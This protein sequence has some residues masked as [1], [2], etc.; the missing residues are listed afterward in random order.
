MPGSYLD[1]FQFLSGIRFITNNGINGFV[2]DTYTFYPPKRLGMLFQAGIIALL[3]N[4]G[5]WGLWQST[6]AVV[7]PIFLFYLTPTLL[8]LVLVPILGYRL[9]TLQN[10]SYVFKRD[11]IRL[12]WG[13]R[14]VTIPT[15]EIL[16]VRPITELEIPLSLP[17]FRWPGAMLGTRNLP[18][19]RPVEFLASQAATLTLIGTQQRVYAISPEEPLGFSRAY[20]RLIE[21]GSLNP[22]QAISIHPSFLFAR[23]WSALPARI[24][25]IT[26]LLESLV[27]FIWVSLLIP[28]YDQISLGFTPLVTPRET[29]PSIQLMLI[30]I[31][32]V[33]ATVLNAVLGIFFYRSQ[34]N[35][36]WAYLLWA[37]SVLV[38]ALFMMAIYYVTVIS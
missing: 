14:V 33:L 36:P 37:T 12:Q 23:V 5:A 8:A 2:K 34:E 25:L 31:L 38:G 24:L 35:H 3:L 7:G 9:Y 18:D 20:Q 13:W 19:G 26:A 29:I 21:L 11:H 32:N 10:A 30:P 27:M 22:T 16:W 6:R 15:N 28:Q 17:W 4:I 1:I